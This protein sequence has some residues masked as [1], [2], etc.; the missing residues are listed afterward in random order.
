MEPKT[1]RFTSDDFWF[2]LLSRLSFCLRLNGGSC[3]LGWASSKA[4]S[5]KATLGLSR[6]LLHRC[7]KRL[8]FDRVVFN[9]LLLREGRGLD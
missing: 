7:L 1:L 9:R 4:R 3:P 8:L 2:L 5:H 6:G